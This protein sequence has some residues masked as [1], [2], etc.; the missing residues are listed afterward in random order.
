MRRH[1]GEDPFAAPTQPAWPSANYGEPQPGY[2]PPSGQNFYFPPAAETDPNYGFAQPAAGQPA[3]G[4][5]SPAPAYAAAPQAGA[6][7]PA[8]YSQAQQPAAPAWNQ[9]ADPMGYDL[10]QYLPAGGQGYAGEGGQDPRFAAHQGYGDPDGAY[11]EMAEEDEEPRSGR[12]GLLIAVA[13]VGAIGLGGAMAYTYKSFMGPASGRAPLIKLTDNGPFKTRPDNPGGREFAHADKKLL[14]RLGEQGAAPSEP[15]TSDDR[16]GDDPNAPRKVRIIPIAGG[17]PEM[18]TTGAP[19]RTGGPV[20]LSV[21]G[22]MLENMA[23]AAQPPPVSRGEMPPAG[24]AQPPVRV[25]SAPVPT[26]EPPMAE[27]AAPARK[28]APVRAPV[29]KVKEA[30]TGPAAAATSGTSGFVAVLA[31]KKSRMDALKAF[32]DLQQKYGD[33]LASKTPDVQEVNLGD[34]GVWYRAVVGPPGSREAAS[35]VCGLLKTA[36]HTSCWVAAY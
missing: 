10:G 14:N 25:V 34:K 33:V 32:A 18:T 12:R 21:P 15:E 17:G 7:A 29:P 24:R 35:S 31:S 23:P 30:S 16:S 26:A 2:A 4:Y 5:A 6:F 28:A 8:L 22:V 13:L 9:Q 27:P 3:N 19:A 11:D 1:P 36:G 20:S